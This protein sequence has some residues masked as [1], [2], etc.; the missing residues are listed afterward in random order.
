MVGVLERF[1]E[2]FAEVRWWWSKWVCG[3]VGGGGQK[4]QEMQFGQGKPDD[5]GQ[6]PDDPGGSG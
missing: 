4:L 2:G 5:P 3:G 6:E 1:A